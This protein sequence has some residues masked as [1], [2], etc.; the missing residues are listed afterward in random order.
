MRLG[1]RL[2]LLTAAVLALAI[3]AAAAPSAAGPA[4]DPQV[5]DQGNLGWVRCANL[6][7]GTQED[8]YL[9]PFGDPQHPTVLSHKSYGGV[10]SYM[11]VGGQYTV[12]VP[13]PRRGHQPGV[14]LHQ[15]LVGAGINYTVASI[16]SGS[17]QKL[18]VLQDQMAGT[19]GEALVRVIQASAK[20]SGVTVA[21]G[22]DT[23]ARDLASGSV[24]S[25]QTVR[26]GTPTVTFSAS[27]G[28][29]SM[30]VSLPS[31]S[32]HTIVVLDGTSGLKIDNLTDA[33]G[34]KDTP[35]GGAATGFGGTVPPPGPDL[36][37]WLATLAAGLLLAAG[38]VL[39]LRRSPPC[40]RRG[41]TGASRAADAH[42]WLRRADR[43]S[44]GPG[45]A[46]WSPPGP[47]PPGRPRAPA[48]RARAW[49]G[50]VA[51]PP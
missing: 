11:P 1:K 22:A 34:S 10:S 8:V 27:G 50:H 46:R 33:A 39:G 32:V 35:K 13:P 18:R 17:G 19:T 42:H 5:G 7:Q 43:R 41:V 6:F 25:Y 38:G 45:S 21:I 30:P 20:E 9:Y 24:T 2:V 3:G 49:S 12:A 31:G 36:A 40:L 23:L 48:R 37:P 44:P 26:P 47:P 16:K 15:L 51:V 28:H 14:D 4:R 29:A